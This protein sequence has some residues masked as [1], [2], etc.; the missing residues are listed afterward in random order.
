MSNRFSKPIIFIYLTESFACCNLT[1][2]GCEVLWWGDLLGGRCKGHMI[3][4]VPQ[5][6]VVMATG[7]CKRADG[8]PFLDDEIPRPRYLW[9]FFFLVTISKDMINDR[10]KIWIQV[11]ICQKDT[12]LLCNYIMCR[13]VV[14]FSSSKNVYTSPGI[15]LLYNDSSPS[16]IYNQNPRKTHCFLVQ[17]SDKYFLPPCIVQ[18][19]FRLSMWIPVTLSSHLFKNFRFTEKRDSSPALE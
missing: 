14:K 6:T 12:S 8:F 19:A 3:C 1:I 11:I 13:C 2:V 5:S 16:F 18:F 10:H 15:I 17:C 9:I 4:F 7:L